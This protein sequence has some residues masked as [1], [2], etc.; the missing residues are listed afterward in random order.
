M[1]NDDVIQ[2]MLKQV[3]IP[4]SVSDVRIEPVADIY[5]SSTVWPTMHIGNTYFYSTD[6][7]KTLAI[8]DENNTTFMFTW[9]DRDIF[10]TRFSVSEIESM[11]N[12][13]YTGTYKYISSNFSNSEEEHFQ[14]SCT[15]GTKLSFSTETL[16]KEILTTL[17]KTYDEAFLLWKDSK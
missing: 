14:L 6:M 11:E 3:M 4:N 7:L 17:S 2:M 16:I 10:N 1:L 9:W 13:N 15:T 5:K 12:E 8:E